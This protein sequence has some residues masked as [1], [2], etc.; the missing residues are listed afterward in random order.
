MEGHHTPIIE[1]G[2]WLLVQQ[3]RKERRYAKKRTRHKKPRYVIKGPL[4]GFM[5]A[6]PKWSTA[7]V[8]AIWAQLFE[9]PTLASA[10]ILVEDENFMIEKE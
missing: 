10:P 7:D 6:D 1:K 4:A 5:I 8:D 9:K 2:D 3:I